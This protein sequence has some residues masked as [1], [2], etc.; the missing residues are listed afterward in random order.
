M[1]IL[2][3]DT[4]KHTHTHTVVAVDEHGRKLAQRTVGTTTAAHLDMITWADALTEG[5]GDRREE[6][7]W[8]VEDCRHLSRRLERDLLATGR[9][10]VRVAEDDG[11]RPRCCTQLRQVRPH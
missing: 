5:A 6:K 7:T 11:S 2:G 1:V 10:V 4:H 8:A 3:I 9:R